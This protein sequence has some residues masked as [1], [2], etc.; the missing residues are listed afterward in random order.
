[1]LIERTKSRQLVNFARARA[2]VDAFARARGLQLAVHSDARALPSLTEQLRMFARARVVV[3]PHGAGEVHLI[4]AAPRT[5]VVEMLSH[6]AWFNP[7]YARLAYLLGHDYASVGMRR[8]RPS[9]KGPGQPK[10]AAH[11]RYSANETE[12][13]GALR[14]CETGSQSR[15]SGGA[16]TRPRGVT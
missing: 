5:C 12:L 13:A 15:S 16:M 9:P 6:D 1:V 11:H 8:E 10:P 4:A 7:C 14:R 2:L 3:A